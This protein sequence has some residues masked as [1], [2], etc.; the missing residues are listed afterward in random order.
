MNEKSKRVIVFS[1]FKSNFILTVIILFFSLPLMAT[2]LSKPA[3]DAIK[4][5]FPGAVI[6]EVDSEREHGVFYYEAEIKYKGDKLEVEVS[7]DGIIG[8]VEGKVNFKNLP[9]PVKTTARKYLKNAKIRWVEKHERRGT[10]SAGSWVPLAKP[11]MYYEVKYKLRGKKRSI[12]IYEDGT[13][14][15]S[16]K[17]IGEDYDDDDDEIA[18]N[19]LPLAVKQAAQKT[20][21]DAELKEAE[22]ERENGNVF[23]EVEAER[24]ETKYS[25]KFDSTG[26][27]VEM[28]KEISPKELPAKVRETIKK[29]Y[30][31]SRVIETQ[32]VT[33][34]NTTNYEV[35]LLA[36][37]Y[38]IEVVL[39]KK[40]KVISQQACPIGFEDDDD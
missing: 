16:R 21:P 8:E 14:V 18:I 7:P 40:G 28:E 1:N 12:F 17:K 32:E 13:L 2:E 31:K 30:S 26:K 9:Q 25:M 5:A 20:L 34:G 23:Y 11:I 3:E 39:D 6:D 4:Q 38:R 29:K 24:G 35:E 36:G 10:A 37:K 33:V 19:E 15:K 22:I 27:L